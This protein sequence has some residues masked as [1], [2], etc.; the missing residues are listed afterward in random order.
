MDKQEFCSEILEEILKCC[1]AEFFPK[2]HRYVENFIDIFNHKTVQTKL[3]DWTKESRDKLTNIKRS[4]SVFDILKRLRDALSHLSSSQDLNNFLNNVLSS[5]FYSMLFED[6]LKFLDDENKSDISKKAREFL[7]YIDK[8]S[9][10]RVCS[11]TAFEQYIATWKDGKIRQGWD[12]KRIQEEIQTMR[13]QSRIAADKNRTSLNILTRDIGEKFEVLR[14][15]LAPLQAA[16]NVVEGPISALLTIFFG[17]DLSHKTM[18]YARSPIRGLSNNYRRQEVGWYDNTKQT[19]VDYIEGKTTDYQIQRF[20]QAEELEQDIH[21]FKD[22]LFPWIEEVLKVLQQP[23]FCLPKKSMMLEIDRLHKFLYAVVLNKPERLQEHQDMLSNV[24]RESANTSTVG[25]AS[26]LPCISFGQLAL[27][28]GGRERIVRLTFV[29]DQSLTQEGVRVCLEN[30]TSIFKEHLKE[31]ESTV[32][33]GLKVIKIDVAIEDNVA[34]LVARA[35]AKLADLSIKGVLVGSFGLGGFRHA[36]NPAFNRIYSLQGADE[37]EGFISTYFPGALDRGGE[38]YFCPNG[39][40]RYAIDVGMTAKQFECSYGKWHVAYHGTEG[41]IAMAILLSGL[42]ASGEGCFKETGKG[43][44]YLSSSIEYSG[45]PR[46]ARVWKVKGKY[47]QMV[48]QVR[49]QGTLVFRKKRGTLPGAFPMNVGIDHNYK[50]NNELEWVIS[51]PP[52]SYMT[53]NNGILV[54]GLMLRVTDEHPG[55]LP[56]NAWWEQSRIEEYW[57]YF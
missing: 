16:V 28:G 55:R 56:H 47:V 5:G 38:P 20:L 8:N 21:H 10:D 23:A 7:D 48:L 54:Y 4:E 31:C 33:N 50:D 17:P 34:G 29:L 39:W 41:H 14:E 18:D 52:G 32:D 11:D 53:S 2:V 9:K 35:V 37:A 22:C 57:N 12:P 45:H 6:E 49:V 51:W 27:A 40:R 43:V 19:I 24:M 36:M 26:I 42:K 1:E 44:I 13:D 30:I 46:Y 25:N 15:K 3:Q